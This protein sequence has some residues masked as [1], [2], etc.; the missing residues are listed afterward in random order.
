VLELLLAAPLAF[1]VGLSLGLLGGGGSILTVPVL[2]YVLHVA[3][4]TAIATSLVV[5]GVTSVAGALRHARHR[6]LD[7]RVGLGFGVAGIVGAS[8]GSRVAAMQAVPGA[9][10]LVAFAVLM[11]IVSATMLRGG[12]GSGEPL[13]AGKRAEVSL[14]RVVGYGSLSGALTGLLGVGGGF[15][16]V[17]MLLL[18]AR[19]P[20]HLAVGTSLIVIALNCAAGL[21]GFLGHVPIRWSLALTFAVV[22]VAGSL[23]GA[24]LAPRVRPRRLR[25]AF[26]ILVLVTGTAILIEKGL[27]I[28][29]GSVGQ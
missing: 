27:E 8:V 14:I 2:V 24:T 29:G 3:P 28:W 5:V 16:I 15:V 9:A 10:L 18:V 25:R 1:L 7:L 17:P 19:L 6:N 26:A 22:S 12:A 13:A 23:V 11:V 20:M 21:V 4:K